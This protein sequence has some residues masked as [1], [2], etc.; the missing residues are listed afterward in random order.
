M[1]EEMWQESSQERMG[2][3]TKGLIQ[4]LFKDLDNVTAHKG[5]KI[6]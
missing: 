4:G 5:K 1:I 3:E 2:I 6:S